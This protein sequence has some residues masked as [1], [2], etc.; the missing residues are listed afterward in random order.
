VV[1][2]G[3]VGG[4]AS[5]HGL[6]GDGPTSV[7]A[8][9]GSVWIGMGDGSL[10]QVD[11]QTGRGR[12]RLR[13]TATGF[14][15]EVA[16]TADAVWVLRDRL[17]RLDPRSGAV[18]EVRGV[19]GGTASMMRAGRGALWIVDDGRNEV[20]RVD[21]RRAAVVARIHVPGRAWGVGAGPAGVIVVSVPTSGPVSG[22]DGI[23]LL[24][25]INPET[26]RLSAPISRVDCDVG[27]TSGAR[28]VWTLDGCTGV[29]VRRAPAS[30]GVLRQR[31]FRVVSQAPLI[32]LGS[33]WLA[34]RSGVL[35]LDAAT[36]QPVARI[37]ARS[38]SLTSGDGAI[39]AFDP[40]HATLRRIDPLTNRVTS[41]FRTNQQP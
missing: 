19:G 11:A 21:P 41:A 3:C 16:V 37:P 29:L 27:V 32:G 6:K 34:S 20:V 25:R 10:V 28:A 13:A 40:A 5:A 14:V 33:V 26:S 30:L 8:G 2:G 38:T 18:R 23:R 15:H 4:A 17:L 1:T 9:F 7:A 12:Q 35:R 39:W 31:K 36:L 22:P 24:R